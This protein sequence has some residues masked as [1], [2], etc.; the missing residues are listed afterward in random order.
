MRKEGSHDLTI[1]SSVLQVS[2]KKA[3][4]GKWDEK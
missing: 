1:Q 4:K 2:E 3:V